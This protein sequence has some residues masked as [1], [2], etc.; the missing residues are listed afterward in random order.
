MHYRH[1]NI[2]QSK[3]IIDTVDDWNLVTP[4]RRK[5]MSARFPC[6]LVPLR[7][8]WDLSQEELVA[9]L[10]RGSRNRVSD[11]ESGNA[12]PNA[13]E[14]LAYSLIFGF[15]PAKIFPEFVEQVEDTVMRNALAL[16]QRLEPDT[17]FQAE[18]KRE[19]LSRIRMNA[20]M[21]PR[22]KRNA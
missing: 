2:R 9:L 13:E 12:P 16:H 22:K 18:L 4:D 5:I 11:V 20:T 17:S 1:F 15:P 14:I 10:P 3:A 6:Y 19:F 7:K 21:L 8:E